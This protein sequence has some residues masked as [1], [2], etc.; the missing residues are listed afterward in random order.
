[1]KTK[2]FFTITQTKLGAPSEFTGARYVEHT[3]TEL[4]QKEIAEDYQI[5]LHAVRVES[6]I[7][8]K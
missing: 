7:Q 3:D 4:F 5:P 6:I 2:M 8:V 1:M